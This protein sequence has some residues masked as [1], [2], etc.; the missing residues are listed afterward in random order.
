MTYHYYQHVFMVKYQLNHHILLVNSPMAKDQRVRYL[1][2]LHGQR[3]SR[4]S[5][6]PPGAVH[7]C[8]NYR[9]ADLG[10]GDVLQ[11]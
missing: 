7:P 10:I 4:R 9:C 11:R 5:K 2:A 6:L 1:L 3:C 8:E